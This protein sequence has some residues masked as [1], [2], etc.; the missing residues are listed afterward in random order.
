MSVIRAAS[1]MM[2]TFK[3]QAPDTSALKLAMSSMNLSTSSKVI[4]CASLPC[5][6]LHKLGSFKLHAVIAG[7]AAGA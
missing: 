6:C 7:G 2:V 5:M 4:C 1:L 3:Y